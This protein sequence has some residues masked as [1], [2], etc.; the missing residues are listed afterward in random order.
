MKNHFKSFTLITFALFILTAFVPAQNKNF[1]VPREESLLN[2]LKVLIV[3]KPNTGRVSVD[4]RVHSG[5][6]F[7]QKGK[8]GTISL[9]TDITFADEGIYDFFKNNASC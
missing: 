9:L 4:L 6:A 8:E 1:P 3:Q 2:G 5:S 7:D